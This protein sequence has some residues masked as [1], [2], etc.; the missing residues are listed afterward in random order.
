[1]AYPVYQPLM[2]SYHSKKTIGIL[3]GSF[4]PAHEGH[5]HIADMAV[6]ALGLDEVWWMVSPQNP[7]KSK[8]GM[9][10]LAQRIENAVK[11]AEKCHHA[12]CMRITSIEAQL[13]TNLTYQ[14]VSQLRKRMHGTRLV[15]IMGSDQSM[16]F[17]HRRILLNYSLPND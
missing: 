3:G 5:G 8:D 1:M 17:H 4:N 12:A 16:T 10:P 15:W 14:T 9:A 13:G 11:I 7:L 6:Q 2:W